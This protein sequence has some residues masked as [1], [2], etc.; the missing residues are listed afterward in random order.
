[1]QDEVGEFL[2]SI[3]SQT[4]PNVA[5][6]GEMETE[7]KR[8]R[9]YKRKIDAAST[10]SIKTVIRSVPT[11]PVV[12]MDSPK[13]RGRAL[14]AAYYESIGQTPPGRKAFG[15]TKRK[16]V[17]AVA[18]VPGGVTKRKTYKPRGAGPKNN[19]P[20]AVTSIPGAAELTG[21][22][23]GQIPPSPVPFSMPGGT[24][25]SSA[26]PTYTPLGTPLPAGMTMLN[27]PG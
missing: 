10:G 4:L 26:F 21:L 3:L 7:P 9:P 6:C 20:R 2:G 15:T 16:R 14:A 25:S 23:T 18:G 11:S 22:L 17:K 12:S 13:S 5:D 24:A 1:M 19:V 8:R 27:I